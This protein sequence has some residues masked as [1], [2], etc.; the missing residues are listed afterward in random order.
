MNSRVASASSPPLSPQTA[1]KRLPRVPKV[2]TPSARRISGQLTDDSAAF[3]A[4]AL[5]ISPES[6]KMKMKGVQTSSASAIRGNGMLITPAKTPKSK[7]ADNAANIT[8]IARNLFPSR[9]DPVDQVMPTPK[10]KGRKKYT[11]FT[12]DSFHAADDEPPIQIYTDSQDR[13]PEPDTSADNPFF[14]QGAAV[15]PEPAKRSTRRSRKI[16]IPGEGEQTVEE[17]EKREDGL[18]YV[19]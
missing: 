15:P 19:L 3:A 5:G 18:V 11:G 9:A 16:H 8:A 10:R 17:A 4:D 14:G 13:V 6:S 1:R 2:P 7:T 12:L